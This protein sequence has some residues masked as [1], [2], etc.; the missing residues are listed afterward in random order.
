MDTVLRTR[1][2]VYGI[3]LWLVLTKDISKSRKGFSKALGP[4][5]DLG[6]CEGYCAWQDD[7]IVLF[8][9]KGH[10]TMKIAAHEAFH[11]VHRILEAT[12]CGWNEGLHEP[13][14]MLSGYIMDIVHRFLRSN[15][16]VSFDESKRLR[17]ENTE[18]NSLFTLQ[19]KRLAEATAYWQKRTGKKGV[20]PDLGQLLTFLLNEIK[21]KNRTVRKPKG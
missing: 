6:A 11:A 15:G 17:E 2:P 9:H 10:T 4:L 12:G 19:S 8:F 18:I 3:R 13:G 7:L 20:L 14:G 5:D 16:E 21:D 1:I